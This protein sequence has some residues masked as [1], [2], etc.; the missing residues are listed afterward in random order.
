[1]F[2]CGLRDRSWALSA[3]NSK[4]IADPGMK[5]DNAN[6]ERR[7]ETPTMFRA[8]ARSGMTCGVNIR[9]QRRGSVASTPFR[10]N[11][12]AD[13][14][15]IALPVS[16]SA[17]CPDTL[18]GNEQIGEASHRRI[19]RRSP[20]R[21]VSESNTSARAASHIRRCGGGRLSYQAGLRDFVVT[22]FHNFAA[23]TAAIQNVMGRSRAASPQR[24]RSTRSG[25]T[26]SVG[27]R[28]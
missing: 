2:A 1:M 14:L 7:S 16:F 28:I 15:E 5:S 18:L 20:A 22:G 21:S 23:A 19:A 26:V 13:L 6:Q 12:T 10:S 17:N 4:E 27:Y 9:N 25:T 3:V 24:P 11:I 8:R